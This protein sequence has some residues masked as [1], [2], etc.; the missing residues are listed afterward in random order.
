[1]TPASGGFMKK[2]LLIALLV[3]LFDIKIKIYEY[4]IEYKGLVSLLT[5][6]IKRK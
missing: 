1:M 5:D 6:F 4:K 3:S 2:I